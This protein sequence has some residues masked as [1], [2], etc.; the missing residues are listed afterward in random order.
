M[1]E[2]SVPNILRMEAPGAES[3]T[4]LTRRKMIVI[5][6]GVEC[7]LVIK[8]TKASRTHCR[9]TKDGVSF[10][11]EDLGSSNGTFVDG[12]RIEGPVQLNL[13]QTFKVGDTIFYL[14]Q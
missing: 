8:D 4:S 6:R 5:G 3:E 1:P 2:K 11:L 14:S 12:K 10:R 7:D 9:L 13:N